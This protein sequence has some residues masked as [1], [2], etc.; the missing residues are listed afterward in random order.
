MT[1]LEQLRQFADI[2]NARGD[3]AGCIRAHEMIGR[4]EAIFAAI[5]SLSTLLDALEP[6]GIE[7]SG[8]RVERRCDA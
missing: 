4:L 8:S 3:R 5:E 7:P 2:A 6:L 1:E